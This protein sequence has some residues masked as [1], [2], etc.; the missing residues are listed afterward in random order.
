VSPA[1]TALENGNYEKVANLVN[2]LELKTSEDY[3]LL[4]EALFNSGKKKSAHTAWTKCIQQEIEG[5]KKYKFL[6]SPSKKLSAAEKKELY[7]AFKAK[8]KALNAA[9]IGGL[10]DTA[11]TATR[12]AD[13][14]EI[15]AKRKDA[16]S[17][18][19]TAKAKATG[20]SID[21]LQKQQGKTTKRKKKTKGIR[22]GLLGGTIIII[23]IICIMI[24]A[25]KSGSKGSS[26]SNFNNAGFGTRRYDVHG[27]D[28][29]F[30]SGSFWHRGNYYHNE[31][32]YYLETG[33]HYTNSM[34]LDNYDQYGLGQ[35]R[36]EA[37]DTK[38]QQEIEK[39]EDLSEAAADAGEQADNLRADAEELD[40]Q[41]D[42]ANEDIEE[43]CETAE[44]LDDEPDFEVD[45]EPE[46]EEEDDDV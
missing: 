28:D 12:T 19:L 29:Y 10:K 20:E 43:L 36:D 7:A 45:E 2:G 3:Y 30:E 21:S 8:Y 6:F 24:F 42:E 13:Q 37:L 27:N 39:R 31:R 15:D 35:G 9:V 34:Y 40:N 14:K 22:I 16:K 26:S 25:R 33:H 46:E 38:I 4:G 23:I 41:A 5:E 18:S 1:R 17:N 32:D 11:K 44:A